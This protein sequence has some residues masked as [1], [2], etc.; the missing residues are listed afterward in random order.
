MSTENE[1]SIIEFLT[2]EEGLEVYI[3]NVSASISEVEFDGE[4]KKLKPKYEIDEF[5][6]NGH[7][8]IAALVQSRLGL[9]EVSKYVAYVSKL[10]Q[11]LG[12]QY[13]QR[14]IEK[15]KQESLGVILQGRDYTL[16]L[17]ADV[18]PVIIRC[19]YQH[20]V[21]LRSFQQR[22]SKISDPK[23]EDIM[24]LLVELKEVGDRYYHQAASV[25]H[26]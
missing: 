3:N 21:G 20:L 6:P 23:P 1:H 14:C 24:K 18:F 15:A 11:G 26:T 19:K 2:D 22:V 8:D 9:R 25:S 7:D 13:A 4:D 16:D 10:S 5:I 17:I 12:V